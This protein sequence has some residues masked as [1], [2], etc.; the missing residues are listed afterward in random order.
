MELAL[1]FLASHWSIYKNGSYAVK[2]TVLKLAFAKP[3]R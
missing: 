3:P 2:Q 1:N